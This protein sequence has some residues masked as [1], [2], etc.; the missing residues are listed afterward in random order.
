MTAKTAAPQV[1]TAEPRREA[2]VEP[3]QSILDRE[4]VLGLF[5]GGIFTPRIVTGESQVGKT[6]FVNEFAIEAKKQGMKVWLLNLGYS[7]ESPLLSIADRTCIA[8]WKYA[9]K[10]A[11]ADRKSKIKEAIQLLQDFALESETLLIVDE[12]S[13]L[14]LNEALDEVRESLQST[15]DEHSID[16][17]KRRCGIVMCATPL[18]PNKDRDKAKLTGVESVPF[19]MAKSSVIGGFTV[20]SSGVTI[21]SHK[22]GL[23]PST[24][25][26]RFVQMPDGQMVCVDLTSV[27]RK[28]TLSNVFDPLPKEAI[29][30][31]T[32]AVGIGLSSVQV[33]PSATIA[34]RPS[35][36]SR[37]N[38]A[39]MT[40]GDW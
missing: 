3:V 1:A 39:S 33:E 8:G 35:S 23:D 15:I 37:S 28:V 36:F 32:Y 21:D 10:A 19:I 14:Y 4:T 18:P 16:G 12:L 5:C 9:A 31:E 20:L 2:K 30:E 13:T 29:V 27:E 24:P 6:S 11:P 17:R 40:R 26:V 22:K 34:Q 7:D 38:G 25:G